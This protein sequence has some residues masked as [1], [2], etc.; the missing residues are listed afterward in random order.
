MRIPHG[1]FFYVI[2]QNYST[3]KMKM[4]DLKSMYGLLA[5]RDCEKKLECFLQS[6]LTRDPP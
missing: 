2:L 6:I 3:S 5:H 4:I 1:L